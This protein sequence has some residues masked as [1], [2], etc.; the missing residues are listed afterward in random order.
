LRTT[1]V[2]TIFSVFFV[3]F[4]IILKSIFE[5]FKDNWSLFDG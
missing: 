3:K 4:W 5:A 1:G 2:S